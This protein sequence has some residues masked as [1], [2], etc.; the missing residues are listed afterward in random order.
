VQKLVDKITYKKHADCHT[1]VISP[2]IERWQLGSLLVWLL[3]WTACGAFFIYALIVEGYGGNKLIVMIMLLS[4]W[5]YFEVRIGRAYLWRIKGLEII[6]IDHNEFS[7]K[8]SIFNY[9]E[10]KKYQLA[11]F[12]VEDIENM[13]I[14]PTSYSKVMNDSFWQVGQGTIVLKYHERE[15]YFGTQLE[16]KDAAALAKLLKKLVG[17]YKRESEAKVLLDAESN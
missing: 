8:D 15:I 12:E 4:L 10:A 11:E 7:I 17:K 1:V 5:L 6:K 16:N 2:T 14:N 3:A 9:G 13:H